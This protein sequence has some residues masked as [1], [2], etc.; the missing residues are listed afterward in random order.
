[1]KKW[2]WLNTILIVFVF[3]I[4]FIYSSLFFGTYQVDRYEVFRD[5]LT[6][7]LSISALSI[8]A[9]GVA[10]YTI[11]SQN[12]ERKVKVKIEEINSQWDEKIQ[13]EIDRM[14]AALYLELSITYWRQ[15]ER[16]YKI[17]R[18]LTP[19]KKEFLDLALRTG[20][21]ALKKVSKLDEK[22]FEK[23]LCS[24]KNNLAYH[25]AVRGF[26]GDFQR[27]ID[28]AKYAYDRIWNFDYEDTWIWVETYAFVLVTMGSEDQKKEGLGLI[29]ELV[30]R[31]DIENWYKQYM[32]KKY[33]QL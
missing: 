17:G 8:A 27:I 14:F 13:C 4:G 18:A 28:L 2:H 12:F 3:I 15:Y 25:L 30:D 20:E 23:L 5:I 11:V 16:D 29:K 6:L 9:L 10:I 24:V 33:G 22:K 1:M 26:A 7:I 19:E 31:K 21:T 32:K